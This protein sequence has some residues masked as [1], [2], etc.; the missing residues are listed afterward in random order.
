MGLDRLREPRAHVGKR[1]LVACFVACT[2]CSIR[3]FG[4]KCRS[5][6]TDQRLQERVVGWI[7]LDAGCPHV[8]LS[9]PEVSQRP[10]RLPELRGETG[11]N[12]HGALPGGSRLGLLGDR[13]HLLQ[14]LAR[15][16]ARAP[17]DVDH[18]QV[19]KTDRDELGIVKLAAHGDDLTV[20]RLSASQVAL[21]PIQLSD[22]IGGS[23]K[24]MWIADLRRQREAF[25]EIAARRREVTLPD[26][27]QSQRLQRRCNAEP[28]VQLAG[29]RQAPLEVANRLGVVSE[30][31]A[32]LAD[33]E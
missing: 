24:L 11:R 23:S 8:R 14:R 15:S 6:P 5:R 13:E 33:G 27:R 2:L 12:L 30:E 21:H 1:T 32:Q 3:R 20:E 28:V 7:T 4:R 10:L 22:G 17:R 31:R 16:S 9:G 26:R 25:V 19:Q 29:D 18:R